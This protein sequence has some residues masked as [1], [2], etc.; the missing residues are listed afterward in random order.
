MLEELCDTFLNADKI[1]NFNDLLEKIS[2]KIHHQ[3][4]LLHQNDVE[5]DLFYLSPQQSLFIKAL[6]E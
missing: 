5:I 3:G 1:K 6:I 2:E 4:Y